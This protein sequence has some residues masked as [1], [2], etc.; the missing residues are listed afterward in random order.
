MG[1]YK[2]VARLER[3][4]WE[5]LGDDALGYAC[6][7]PIIQAY[8][9]IQSR[10]EDFTALVYRRL[11]K[12]Q[13]ALFPFQTYYQHA[14]ESPGDLYWWTAYYRAQPERWEALRQ[15]LAYVQDSAVLPLLARIEEVLLLN[16]AATSLESFSA[17]TT[18]LE[19]DAALH[20]E[21]GSLYQAFQEAAP[22]ALRCFA[23]YI[24]SHPE[25]FLESDASPSTDRSESFD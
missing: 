20:E 5:L 18:D 10:G 4:E 25:Q 8:K 9:E 1:E 24:R 16:H 6:F 23:S 3:S 11:S 13:Q 21:F 17:S 7:E 12:G 15:G 2:L 22:G 14:I 19:R